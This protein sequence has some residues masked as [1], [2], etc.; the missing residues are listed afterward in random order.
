MASAY[1]KSA[2]GGYKGGELKIVYARFV[3]HNEINGLGRAVGRELM[4]LR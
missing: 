3:A 1:V 2:L 4:V